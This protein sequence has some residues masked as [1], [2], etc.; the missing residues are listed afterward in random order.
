MA[1][2]LDCLVKNPPLRRVSDQTPLSVRPA[3]EKVQ[4]M[5]YH[6]V[7]GDHPELQQYAKGDWVLYA[8]QLLQQR[9]YEPQDHKIDGYFGPMT[10]EA[11]RDFQG[12]HGLKV[13]GIIGPITWPA[14]EGGGGGGGGGGAGST[15]HLEFDQAPHVDSNGW[16]SWSVKNTGSA[17]VAAGTDGGAYEMYD[18][19][20]TT[21]PGSSIP[22]ASDL[23]PGASSGSLATN[24]VVSTPADGDYSASVQLGNVVHYV[25]YRVTNGVAQ[26]N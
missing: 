26:P 3:D 10:K 8:Q 17:T 7:T 5:S 1:K 4:R 15:G 23:A 20:N 16:L 21:I 25:N 18:S 13:D 14:L 11:V 9:G 19:S 24:L 6:D 12:A 2:S 22:I